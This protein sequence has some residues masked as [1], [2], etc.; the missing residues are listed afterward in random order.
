VNGA[1]GVATPLSGTCIAGSRRASR[2]PPLPERGRRMRH[3]DDFRSAVLVP[4][5]YRDHVA[6]EL[7]PERLALR[8]RPLVTVAAVVALALCLLA[9]IHLRA[10]SSLPGSRFDAAW[11]VKI[12]AH[13]TPTRDALAQTI[14]S[15]GGAPVGIFVGVAVAAGIFLLR[16][17]AAALTFVTAA[18]VSESNVLALKWV[19]ERPSPEGGLYLGF[20]GSFP[21]GHTAYAAVI[22]VSVGLL[23]D[24]LLIW[25]AGAAYVAVMGLDRTYLD[26]HWVTDTVAGAVV[27]AAVAALAWYLMRPT[28]AR[29]RRRTE[30][31]TSAPQRHAPAARP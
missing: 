10:A 9:A 21:S 16:G 2:L 14:A 30:L 8:A 11:A 22:V 7:E 1:D 20:L 13:H 5:A 28:T 12:D 24:R 26:A 17:R 27:G 6:V 3:D 29:P 15:I 4:A 31:A 18:A 25:A 19:S 23:A